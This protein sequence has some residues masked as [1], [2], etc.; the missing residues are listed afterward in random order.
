MTGLASAQAGRAAIAAQT[1]ALRALAV[2][3]KLRLNRGNNLSVPARRIFNPF[4]PTCTEPRS[5]IP[6][7]GPNV[8][9]KPAVLLVC[10]S[11]DIAARIARKSFQD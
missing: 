10:P 11:L 5:I 2:R 6:E 9:Q 7:S 4:A 3:G 8:K 1:R